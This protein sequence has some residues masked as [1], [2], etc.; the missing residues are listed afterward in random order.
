MPLTPPRNQQKHMKM[1]VQIYY[2][3]KMISSGGE[4]KYYIS[5]LLSSK[6]YET[7]GGSYYHEKYL[8]NN[9]AQET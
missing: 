1:C 9:P 6:F 4:I 5:K 3:Q 2:D 7:L 8:A